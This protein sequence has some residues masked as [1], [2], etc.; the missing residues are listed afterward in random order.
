MNWLD[1]E[2]KKIKAEEK[3]FAV[4]PKEKNKRDWNLFKRWT[5]VL[6]IVLLLGMATDCFGAVQVKRIALEWVCPSCGYDN[7]A[8]IRYCGLCGSEQ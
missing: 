8:G 7:F 2:V 1:K 5:L 4:H 6:T 3:Y